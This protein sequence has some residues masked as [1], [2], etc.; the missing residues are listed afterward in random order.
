MDDSLTASPPP[1]L[2]DASSDTA[3]DDAPT[4][5][6]DGPIDGSGGKRWGQGSPPIPPPSAD[7]PEDE[8]RRQRRRRLLAAAAA[9]AIAAT[10]L[11]R[12]RRRR[13]MHGSGSMNII[14]AAAAAVG[15]GRLKTAAQASRGGAGGV[16]Y[17]GAVEAPLSDLL[18]AAKKGEV[19]KALVGGSAVVYRI[20]RDTG[21]GAADAARA[22]VMGGSWKR[23][24]LPPSSPSVQ[25]DVLSALSK[26]G[27]VDV[28]ALP[29]PLVARLAPALFAAVPFLYLSIVWRMMRDL[30]DPD[31]SSGGSINRDDLC[32]SSKTTF[33]DVAGVDTAQS[34]LSEIVSYLENPAAFVAVGARPPGGVLL[35]GP[36]GNGKTLLARAIAGE[37]DADY[38]AHCSGSDFVE[39]YVGRGAKRVRELFRSAREGARRAH[40]LRSVPSGGGALSTL[41]GWGA[42]LGGRGAASSSARRRRVGVPGSHRS[43]PPVAVVFIDEIDSLARCRDGIGSVGGSRL[44]SG[45]GDEREHALN[46]LLAEMDGFGTYGDRNSGDGDRGVSV[47]V[48]AATNRPGVLDPALLRPGRFDRNV[49]VPYPDERGRAAILR[50]HLR[51]VRL[52]K[53]GDDAVAEE[54]GRKRHTDGFSGADLRNVVNEA[55]LFAVRDNNAAGDGEG[56]TKRHLIEAACKVQRMKSYASSRMTAGGG[57]IFGL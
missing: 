3:S 4:R 28:S 33:A 19:A 16:G 57:G 51:N 11:W 1:S 53:G 38:F 29:D 39:V 46:A 17:R 47:I 23:S 9:A 35:H 22:D 40:R 14:E 31:G 54:L 5:E 7:D 44:S 34:E 20:V 50:V 21:G 49:N 26:G 36:P 2:S 30:R 6:A 42:Q 13:R 10:Y 15:G 24:A 55:A 12:R 45:T 8:M 56:V 37:A 18:R 27:C 25:S 48:I 43:R 41:L 52:R 32:N